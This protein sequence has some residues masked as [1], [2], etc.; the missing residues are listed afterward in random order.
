MDSL[1]S[2]VTL[3]GD[4][5]Y[6]SESWEDITLKSEEIAKKVSEK[7][8]YSDQID[9][10]YVWI[11]KGSPFSQRMTDV[12]PVKRIHINLMAEYLTAY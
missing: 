11:V 1:G 8:F 12:S 7:G 3:A 6:R 5:W 9:G 10:G 4:I 2:P